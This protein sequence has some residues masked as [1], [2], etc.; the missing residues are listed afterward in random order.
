MNN[1]ENLS[2][3]DASGKS[4]D[5]SRS[6][7]KD[8]FSEDMIQECLRVLESGEIEELFEIIPHI[9]VLRDRRFHAPLLALL[10]HTDVKRREFAAYAMGAMADRDFLEPLKT[11][12]LHTRRINDFG[13][14]ELQIAVIEAIGAIGDDSEVDFLLSALKSFR[15]AKAAR[16]NAGK[17]KINDGMIKSIIEAL[18]YVAQ[19]GGANARAAL[20]ELI[21]HSDPEIQAPALL[22]LS[23]VYWHHPN[24]IS[25]N[26]LQ[27]I[28][29]LTVSENA[30]VA[31]SALS[32]LQNLA[33][34]GC[35]RAEDFFCVDDAEDQ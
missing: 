16:E 17:G 23:V 24:D 3:A 26:L 28:Y 29:D 18:C 25:D 21:T 4:P 9:G 5:K 7:K 22:E 34:A 33:D 11:A 6:H 1:N 30:L 8:G 31:E 2:K 20:T 10:N 14:R 13:A 12:F 15:E 35:R 32:A 19:Q 27:N